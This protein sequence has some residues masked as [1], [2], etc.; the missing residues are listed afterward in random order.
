MIITCILALYMLL[1]I[2]GQGGLHLK[3]MMRNLFLKF[4]LQTQN[5]KDLAR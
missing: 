1:H 2:P 4:Y 3:Y 5:F